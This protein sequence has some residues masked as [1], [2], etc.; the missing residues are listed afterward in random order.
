MALRLSGSPATA[1]FS[2]LLYALC[3]PQLYFESTVLTETLTTFL[4]V[5]SASLVVG[6]TG[7]ERR[8]SS[9]M[10]GG[11][12]LCVGLT[13]LP[14]FAADSTHLGHRFHGKPI[15]DSRQAISTGAK[16]RWLCAFVTE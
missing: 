1:S 6:T 4:L 16:R 12:G 7:P 15:T 11:L 14:G 13:A 2:A 8:R 9:L 5:S 10:L 3:L